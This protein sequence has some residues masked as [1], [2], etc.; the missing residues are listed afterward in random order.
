M[1]VALVVLFVSNNTEV[2]HWNAAIQPSVWLSAMSTVAG[3]ALGL[4][5]TQGVIIAFWR[6]AGQGATVS[7]ISS[8]EAI[9]KLS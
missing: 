9:P 4:A 7:K 1:I 8:I 3:Q 2:A 5:L 6:K